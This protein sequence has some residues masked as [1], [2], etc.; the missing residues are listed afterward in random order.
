[1]ARIER[2]PDILTQVLRKKTKVQPSFQP[3]FKAVPSCGWKPSG[4]QAER[5]K[6]AF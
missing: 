5:I 4:L 1:M 2:Y 6:K 3:G